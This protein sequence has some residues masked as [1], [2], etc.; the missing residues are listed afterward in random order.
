[1]I[2]YNNPFY[3]QLKSLLKE[4][5]PSIG[6][7]CMYSAQCVEVERALA[8]ADWLG[9]RR[10]DVKVDTVDSYQGKE[11]RI[12][13]V[14]LVRNNPAKREGFLNRPFRTNVAMSRAMD[15]LI[16]V[17]AASMWR[18]RNAN[19]PLGRVLT[20]IEQ[21]TAEQSVAIRPVA[22]LATSGGEG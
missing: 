17:G 3:R 19:S 1:M 21:N 13:I 20:F 9:A 11:N 8:R 14:S 16:I 18:G 10:R 15:R 5:E 2:V 12:V 22:E 6:I 4:G 7:I